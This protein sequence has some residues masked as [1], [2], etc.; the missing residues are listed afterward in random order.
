MAQLHDYIIGPFE[1]CS[2]MLDTNNNQLMCNIVLGEVFTCFGFCIFHV[3]ACDCE[4]TVPM[5]MI[6]S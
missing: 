4:L 3:A 6:M 5:S 1:F 2:D